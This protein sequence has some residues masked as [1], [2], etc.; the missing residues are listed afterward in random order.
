MLEKIMANRLKR[1]AIDHNLLPEKQYTAPGRNTTQALECMIAAVYRGWC[2][3]PWKPAPMRSVKNFKGKYVSMMSLDIQSAFDRVP[4]D[5]L[6]KILA[7]RG[8]PNWLVRMVHS[9][10]SHR[11]T[12][13]KLPEHTSRPY[14]VNVGIPQ[15]SPLSP[16]LFMFFAAGLLESLDQTKVL[17]SVPGAQSLAFAFADDHNVM[18]SSNAYETNCKALEKLHEVILG[19][20]GEHGVTFS[21]AKYAIMHFLPPCKQTSV[22]PPCVATRVRQ[23]ALRPRP[24]DSALI[25]QSRKPCC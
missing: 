16:I 23:A 3:S 8:I 11:S 19:W 21:P 7:S 14:W 12:S 15:G 25:A 18:V 13:I 17:E 1:L 24:S 4:R 20:A 6:L 5:K 9:F 2:L 10:L 22:S